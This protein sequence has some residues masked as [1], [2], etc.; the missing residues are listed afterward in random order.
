MKRF[1]QI[2]D[3]FEDDFE[4]EIGLKVPTRLELTEEKMTGLER[5][6][7]TMD[8]I[9][10]NLEKVDE[11]TPRTEDQII[12]HEKILAAACSYIYGKDLYS[13]ELRIKQR[14]H[15]SNIE[16]GV[17]LTAP[18][19][20]GKTFCI[21][22]IIAV[23]FYTVPKIHICIVSQSA[24]SAGREMGILGKIRDVL[25]TVFAYSS[26]I[27]DNKN[28]LVGKFSELD[29]RKIHSFTAGSGDG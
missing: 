19:R 12:V 20:F 29:E 21:V 6:H 7:I 2:L 23:L 1:Q 11:W 14:N 17:L 4:K 24:H 18:R 16:H 5:G 15:F 26:F 28:H 9:R 8:S 25:K 10:R 27:I 13:N 3:I 22:V